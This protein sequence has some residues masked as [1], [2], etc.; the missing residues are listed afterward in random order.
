MFPEI[1]VILKFMSDLL[2]VVSSTRWRS[3]CA[4]KGD[5]QQEKLSPYYLFLER[6]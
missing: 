2:S 4:D 1:G 5:K 3:N 6:R